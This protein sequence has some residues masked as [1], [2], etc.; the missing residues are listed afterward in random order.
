MAGAG[1]GRRGRAGGGC[2]GERGAA[3]LEA[4][5]VLPLLGLLVFG[6]IDFAS[7]F[8]D[9]QA[10]RQ[11]TREGA[12]QGSVS[13]TPGPPGG[14]SW[15]STNCQTAGIVTSGDGYD[16]VCDLKNR[17]GLDESKTRVSI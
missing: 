10:L 16:I 3:A 9:F 8:N 13:T 14:G 12:R 2:S 1:M 6:M 5:I 4:A 7:V 15:N 17:A 11:G